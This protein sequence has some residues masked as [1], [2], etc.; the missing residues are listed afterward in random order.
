MHL[1]IMMSPA[2][3]NS[4]FY[5]NRLS[6]GNFAQTRNVRVCAFAELIIQPV[7]L[8]DNIQPLPQFS[9][10]TLSPAN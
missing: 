9:D 1:L 6:V 4:P 7:L 8:F 3:G 5:Q 10:F 2:S